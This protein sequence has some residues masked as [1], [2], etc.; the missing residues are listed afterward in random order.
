MLRLTVS[1]SVISRN[2]IVIVA[3]ARNYNNNI[4]MAAAIIA[5]K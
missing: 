3:A 5:T 2:E 1:F 4:T